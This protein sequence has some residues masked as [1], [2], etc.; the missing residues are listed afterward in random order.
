MISK[1][2]LDNGLTLELYDRSKVVAGDR[3]LVSFIARIDVDVRKEYFNGFDSEMPFKEIKASLGERVTYSYEKS[4][5]FI[6][7]NEKDEVLLDLK[8]KYLKSDLQYLSSPEFPQKLII[9]KY[10]QTS[11][12]GPKWVS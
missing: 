8:D 3:W 7:E 9:S 11:S 4:R 2:D 1:I 6:D 10:K 12:P 5:N